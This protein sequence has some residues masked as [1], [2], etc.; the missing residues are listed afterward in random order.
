MGYEANAQWNAGSSQPWRGFRL[1]RA[2][3][4]QVAG[5]YYGYEAIPQEWICDVKDYQW[6]DD[7]INQF[8]EVL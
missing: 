7:F 2:V 4:G 3:Y 5:A 6:V 1:Y 8:L